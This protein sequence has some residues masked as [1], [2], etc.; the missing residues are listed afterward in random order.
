MK[1]EAYRN[2][3]TIQKETK[4][5]NQKKLFAEKYFLSCLIVPVSSFVKIYHKVQTIS[6]SCLHSFPRFVFLET[7]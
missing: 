2:S 6:A 3:Q 5:S 7:F 1:S 4:S